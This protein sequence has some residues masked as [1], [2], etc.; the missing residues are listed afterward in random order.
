[1]SIPDHLVEADLERRN[2]GALPLALLQCGDVLPA[3][4]AQ[5]PEL[6]ELRVEAGANDAAVGDGGGEPF[7]QPGVEPRGEVSEQVEVPL[8]RRE[9]IAEIGRAHGRTPVTG[10]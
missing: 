10:K 7:L 5:G 2:P 3:A 4:V 1:R 8:E 9:V 6:V